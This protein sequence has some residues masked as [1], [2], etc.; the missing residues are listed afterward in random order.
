MTDKVTEIV[1]ILTNPILPNLVKIGRTSNL[2]KQIKSLSSHSG[3]PILFECYYACRVKDGQDIETRLN[4]AFGDHR[5]NPKR[6]FFS[7]NPERVQMILEALS[8]KDVTLNYDVVE[9]D[10]ERGAL[11]KEKSRRPF[12]RFSMVNVEIGSELTF[13]KD[14]NLTCRVVGDREIEFN[15]EVTSLSAATSQLVTRSGNTNQFA[16]PNWWVYENETLS[17]RRLRMESGDSEIN[18]ENTSF[19][20]L[21]GKF[22]AYPFQFFGRGHFIFRANNQPT[23]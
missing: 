4:S 2:E 9:D 15:G 21:T 18:S 20:N 10:Q 23:L 8:L 5:I 3:V 13:L 14:E 1:Y 7:I 6:A 12:F 11:N 17:E 19:G 16:G 22:H